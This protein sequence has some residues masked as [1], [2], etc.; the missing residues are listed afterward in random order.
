M[1]GLEGGQELERG[2]QEPGKGGRSKRLEGG[3]RT[4]EGGDA[5]SGQGGCGSRSPEEPPQEG[6]RAL[7]PLLGLRHELHGLPLLAGAVHRSRYFCSPSSSSSSAAAPGAG[8]ARARGGA[9]AGCGMRDPAGSA[10]SCSSRRVGP[11]QPRR[12]GY[13]QKGDSFGSRLK[14]WLCLMPR[15][16]ERDR[17]LVLAV[18]SVSDQSLS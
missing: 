12:S 5:G 15:E 10:R 8:R 16:W 3:S 1:K 11:A 13:S 14:R 4:W 18:G 9:R 17:S 6:V 2:I 7:D